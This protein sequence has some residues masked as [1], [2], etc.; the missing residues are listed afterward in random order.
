MNNESRK[1][2]HLMTMTIY[3]GKLA[4]KD[5]V[6]QLWSK[7]SLT[8]RF[9]LF[10]SQ[11]RTSIS[12]W[13]MSTKAV[14]LMLLTQTSEQPLSSSLL[15]IRPYPASARCNGSSVPSKNSTTYITASSLSLQL[16]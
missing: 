16:K 11:R 6:A 4:A 1:S 3:K 15:T 14:I 8:N 12:S 13:S 2:L 9:S 5:K 7:P 10:S